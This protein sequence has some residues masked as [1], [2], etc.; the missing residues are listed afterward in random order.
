M[1]EIGKKT[2]ENTYL[3]LRRRGCGKN[4]AEMIEN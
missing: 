3:M 4:I 1:R 2:K